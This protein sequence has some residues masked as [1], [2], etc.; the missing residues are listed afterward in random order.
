MFRFQA[1]WRLCT[2]TATSVD[3]LYTS[4]CI[5]Y[6]FM[7]YALA[8]SDVH[9]PKKILRFKDM[10]YPGLKPGR[11]GLLVQLHITCFYMRTIVHTHTYTQ[12]MS[13]YIYLYIYRYDIYTC[14]SILCIYIYMVLRCYKV[15]L[16][17]NHSDNTINKYIYIF[18]KSSPLLL[19]LFKKMQFPS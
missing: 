11:P 17:N 16:I 5:I 15:C 7:V 6:T 14:I 4:I 9:H 10:S 19:V 8:S 2:T 12:S 1:G 18:S 13:I 3:E